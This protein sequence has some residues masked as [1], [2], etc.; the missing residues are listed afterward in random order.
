MKICPQCK[1]ENA[2]DAGFCVKCGAALGAA[3]AP[4]EAP[5]PAT[6]DETDHTSEFDQKEISEGKVLAMLI[7][8]TSYLGIFICLLYSGKNRYVDFHLRQALK[9]EVVQILVILATALLFWTFIVPIAAGIALLILVVLRFICFF[10]ICSG[11]AKEPAII[12]KLGFLK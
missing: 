2:D 4:Q 7:Y 11:K 10:Q 6:V 12:C 8:L 5:K 3:E 9:I 1:A